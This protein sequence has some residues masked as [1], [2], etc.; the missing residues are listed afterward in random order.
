MGV[1]QRLEGR[2]RENEIANRAATDHQN[3]IHIV[4]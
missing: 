2:Q 3:A 4:L 1:T